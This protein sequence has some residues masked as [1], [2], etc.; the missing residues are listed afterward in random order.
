MSLLR[1]PITAVLV[2]LCSPAFGQEITTTYT[3]SDAQI[4]DRFVLDEFRVERMQE[5]IAGLP[6]DVIREQL[7][8]HMSERTKTVLHY[9]QRLV[10][11]EYSTADGRIFSWMPNSDAVM[12]GTWR[13]SNEAD[14]GLS[15][16]FQ[17]GDA[18]PECVPAAYILAEYCS[19]AIEEADTFGLSSGQLP[20]TR[21]PLEVPG[22]ADQ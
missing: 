21:Q 14:S 3:M 10:F 8:I 1:A 5:L 7:R 9:E 12:E 2:A 15:V 6:E 11:A 22:L 18:D 17:A 19:L 20:Y 16:C 13:I 4:T